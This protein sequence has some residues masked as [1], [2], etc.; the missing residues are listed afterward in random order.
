M[1]VSGLILAV[2]VDFLA[3]WRPSCCQKNSDYSFHLVESNGRKC[4]FLSDIV[5]HIGLPVEIHN[6]RIEEVAGNAAFDEV[7][8]ISVRALAPLDKLLALTS[9]LCRTL[10]GIL[11]FQGPRGCG[12]AGTGE[13]AVGLSCQ[14]DRQSHGFRWLYSGT[15][16]SCTQIGLW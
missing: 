7:E 15:Y 16:G 2:G 14:A 1:V 9:P 5:R 11:F 10:D 4:A 3:L 13:T 8:I 12:G 6:K